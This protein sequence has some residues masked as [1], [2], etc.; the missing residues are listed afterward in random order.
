ML[1]R[2]E[3]AMRQLLPPEQMRR[4]ILPRTPENVYR[5]VQLTGM[6]FYFLHCSLKVRRL[7]GA[8]QFNLSPDISGLFS[9]SYQTFEFLPWKHIC[10]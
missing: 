10:R 4:E 6:R 3:N 5:T 1:L 9:S 7:V 2:S 8:L